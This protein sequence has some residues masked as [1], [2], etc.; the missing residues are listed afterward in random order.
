MIRFNTY[1]DITNYI[2][3]LTLMQLDGE[4]GDN[5]DDFVIEA[6]IN[7]LSDKGYKMGDPMPN[8]SE[9]EMKECFKTGI[10]EPDF[11]R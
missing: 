11:R 2:Q 1:E 3:N 7:L 10:K 9:E 4:Y 5:Y 8:I 6:F